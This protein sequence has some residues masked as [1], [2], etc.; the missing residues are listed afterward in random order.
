MLR[1]S[2]IKPEAFFR[3]WGSVFYAGRD[4]RDPLFQMQLRLTNGKYSRCWQ[5]LRHQLAVLFAEGRL[6]GVVSAAR[7]DDTRQVF[8]ASAGDTELHELPAEEGIMAA[9]KTIFYDAEHDLVPYVVDPNR[10]A[11]GVAQQGDSSAITLAAY[12]EVETSF[13]NLLAGLKEAVDEE[14]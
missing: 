4:T 12:E 2:K 7:R 10:P 14:I 6:Q 8:N 3:G 1:I 13:N 9:L 5:L 11:V